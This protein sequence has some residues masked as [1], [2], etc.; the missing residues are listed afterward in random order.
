MDEP[1][2]WLTDRDAIYCRLSGFAAGSA[3]EALWDAAWH[4]G[5]PLWGIRDLLEVLV[6]TGRVE[7]I[8]R[9]CYWR[10]PL[11]MSVP[12]NRQSWITV[13]DE[14]HGMACARCRMPG[15]V[16]GNRMAFEFAVVEGAMVV[17]MTR[18]MSVTTAIVWTLPVDRAW[19]Q[20]RLVGRG[21]RRGDPVTI[22]IKRRVPSQNRSQ[23]RHWSRIGKN[24]MPGSFSCGSNC[25]ANQ[26]VWVRSGWRSA[27]IVTVFVTSPIWSAVPSRF[28]IR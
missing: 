15:T 4:A 14:D 7:T 24:V 3:D 8:Q 26:M 16:L 17:G 18:R 13:V 23:Y 27:L 28:L 5:V 12:A 25:H 9:P 22:I 20:P 1:A 2:S 21:G 19:S 11:V 10:W 6:A